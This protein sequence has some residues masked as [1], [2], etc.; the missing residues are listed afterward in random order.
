MQV[1]RLALIAILAVLFAPLPVSANIVSLAWQDLLPKEYSATDAKAKALRLRLGSLPEATLEA[2]RKINGQRVLQDDIEKGILKF[3]E[4]APDNQALLKIDYA[5]QFPEA[6]MAAN[7]ADQL[8]AKFNELD[9]MTNTDLDGKIIKVP[10]YVLPLEF[11]DTKTVE[12]LLVP[13]VGACIH[14]PPPPPNQIIHVHFETGFEN[15]G[16]YAPVYITGRLSAVSTTTALF[17]TDG[18]SNVKT[19]YRLEATIVEPYKGTQQ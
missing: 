9:K 15:R 4:L 18:Q 2:Y 13:Y 12:F 10:G 16:L 6:V 14:T 8:Y 1:R 7:E 19:G 5:S 17:L 3:D 11:S